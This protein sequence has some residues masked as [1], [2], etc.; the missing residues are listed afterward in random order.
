MSLYLAYPEVIDAIEDYLQEKTTLAQLRKFFGDR[1]MGVSPFDWMPRFQD[2][3]ASQLFSNAR[4]IL[5]RCRNAEYTD[6]DLKWDLNTLLD[7]YREEP[8]KA[9]V[10]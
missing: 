8:G 10:A 5:F 1:E 3:L 2:I 6:D 7:E 4:N 9:Q